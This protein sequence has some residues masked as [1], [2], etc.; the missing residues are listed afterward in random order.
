MPKAQASLEMVI[1]LVILLVVAAVVISLVINYISPSRVPNP[2]EE[3]SI[4][5]FIEK[6]REYCLDTSTN[7]YCTYYYPGD[8][9]NKNGKKCEIVRVGDYA[10]PACE[11]RVYCFLVVPCEERF[12]SGWNAINKCK[13]LLCQ[14]YTE[15]YGDINLASEALRST[16]QFSSESCTKGQMGQISQC[17]LTEAESKGLIRPEENWYR[18]VF[19]G[20]CRATGGAGGGA[21]G[22]GGGPPSPP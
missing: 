12:G 8:D 15:K 13:E 6:C 10:W 18:K 14:A 17:N 4:K 9:W 11:D 19:E 5:S 21:G 2:K 16:I 3:L 1:G 20:G 22:G 7:D